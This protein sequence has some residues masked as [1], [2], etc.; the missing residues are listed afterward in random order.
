MS[1]API[2][3]AMDHRTSVPP[4]LALVTAGMGPT[5]ALLHGGVG[6]WTHWSRNLEA[7]AKHF[8]VRAFDLPGFGASASFPEQLSD[9]DYFSWVADALIS[10]GTPLGLVGFSFG[11]SVAA[12]V[13]PMLG[14]RLIA[15]TLVAPGSF[16]RPINRELDV[17][18]VR[19]RDGVA[20]DSRE[21]ARHNLREVMFANPETVDDVTVSLHLSNI[22]L[23]R[24]N[25]RRLSWQDRLE[26]DLARVKC[27][28]QMIW[29]ARDRMATPS[30]NA[31]VERCRAMGK[32]IR[33]D[34]IPDAGHWVQYERPDRFNE[35]LLGFLDA[36][37]AG[38]HVA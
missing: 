26:T 3:A 7:L 37:V 34:L 33:F 2:T 28:I 31:R 21:V 11:G 18:S 27:P 20:V 10:L 32:D 16:G 17:R 14:T 38:T 30:V 6:S 23:A 8:A 35:A 22:T 1:G 36:V 24:F 15:L 9:Q 12:A 13:A 19:S 5:L 29:G 25:S 4:K